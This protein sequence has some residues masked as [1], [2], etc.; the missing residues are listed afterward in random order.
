MWVNLQAL[1]TD[2]AGEF[3]G[4]KWTKMVQDSGFN[5]YTSAPYAPSMNS[6]AERVIRTIIGHA[7]AMLWA[8]GLKEEFWALAAKAS[9]YLLIRSSHSGLDNSTPH[10]MWFKVRPHLG[11]VRI[12]GCRTWA[13]VSPGPH[14]LP[15]QALEICG[16]Y[17][18][19]FQV[20]HLPPA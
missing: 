4:K 2:N 18:D 17:L 6:Y 19:K 9:V 11:H 20:S 10:E 14:T 16:F 13:A 1:Q 12:W 15:S 5:H 3:I 8:A 7:S